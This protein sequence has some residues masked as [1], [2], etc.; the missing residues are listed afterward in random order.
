MGRTARPAPSSSRAVPPV[1]TISIPSSARPRAKSTSPR[2]SDTVSSARR[3]CTPP[4]SVTSSALSSVVAI[5]HLLHDHLARRVGVYPHGTGREQPHGTRQ[6]PVLDLVNSILD[7]GDVPRIRINRESLLHDDRAG[8][9]AL[10]DEM[11]RPPHLLDAVVE[12]LLDRPHAREGREE[13]RVHVDD[14]AREA[15]DERLAQQLHEAREHDE[16]RA[17]L[18]EPVAERL[19]AGVA[20][21]LESLPL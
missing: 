8:V 21:V 14:A 4:G 7:S 6:Q 19:V 3:T 13:R 15:P 5:R 16:L 1:E 10:V 20:I 17:A 9:D 11:H 12:C 18:L 2:L